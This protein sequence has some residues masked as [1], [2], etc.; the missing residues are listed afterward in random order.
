MILITGS[1]GFIGSCLVNELIKSEKVIGIDD[2]SGSEKNF[3]KHK[4]YKFI[5]GDCGDKNILNKLKSIKIIIHLAGQSS[6]EKSFE[7]PLDDFKKNTI[8]TLNLLDFARKT[9]CKQFVYASSMSVYGDGHKNKVREKKL[10]NPISFYGLSKE[11]SEKYIRKFKEKGVNYTILRFFN[12][13]GSYQKLGNLKQG[14]I[15]IYLTQ[16][17]KNK[18]LIVKGS[19]KR[20]RDFIHI[21]D[22][23]DY[24]KEVIKDK[25]YLNET[26]NIGTSRKNTIKSLINLLKKKIKYKFRVKFISGT[27]DDQHGIVANINKIKKKSKIVPKIFLSNGLDEMI[28]GNK[29]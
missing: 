9:K 28:K 6:G 17:I 10:T 2:L 12:V 1:A 15:R 22:V 20:F 24:I 25:K 7:D 14:M 8:S 5:K 21:T 13:Y 29:N 11:T 23:I 26:F 4:N 3:I 19:N 27:K 16:I 18:K